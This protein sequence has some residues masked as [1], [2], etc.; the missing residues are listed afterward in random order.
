[1]AAEIFI[2]TSGFYALMVSDDPAHRHSARVLDAARRACTGFVTTDYVLDETATL[3]MARGKV[4][5]L[6]KL[7]QT[8]DAA[9]ACRIEWMNPGLFLEA[10]AMMMRYANRAFSFTDCSSFV[11]TRKLKIRKVLTKDGHF[12]EMGFEV[13]L[14]DK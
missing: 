14:D 9:K 2:D 4:H 1:M 6:E 3:L 10:R 5:L 12:A 13:L 11:L 7:W 8:M